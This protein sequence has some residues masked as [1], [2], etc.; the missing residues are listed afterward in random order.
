MEYAYLLPDMPAQYVKLTVFWLPQ[1]EGY[2]QPDDVLALFGAK[3]EKM[4]MPPAQLGGYGVQI[5]AE[6]WVFPHPDEAQALA[7]VEERLEMDLPCKWQSAHWSSGVYQVFLSVYASALSPDKRQQALVAAQTAALAFYPFGEEDLN[8]AVE[9][10]DAANALL[11]SEG[12]PIAAANDAI[13]GEMVD[14]VYVSGGE[15]YH[16]E[17]CRYAKGG[18]LVSRFAADMEGYTPCKVCSP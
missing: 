4:T 15:R 2:P 9:I 12:R 8:P 1:E 6:A 3:G 11:A 13:T 10:Y 14:P 7:S 16:K 18:Q 17:S 5:L